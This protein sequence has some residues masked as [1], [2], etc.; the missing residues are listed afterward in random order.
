MKFNFSAFFFTAI[1]V[2]VAQFADGRLI[3]NFGNCPELNN[4]YINN[5]LPF[6]GP[7]GV[8]AG[9]AYTNTRNTP[10]NVPKNPSK[11]GGP[12]GL[13]MRRLS[14][15]PRR[16]A[17][18][19]ITSTFT[20]DENAP[21]D[22]D[23]PVA[24]KDF[25][26][27]NVQVEGVDEPDIIKTDGRR[28][29][30]LS[31]SILSVIQVLEDGAAGRRTGTLKL[32]I[33]PREMLFEGDYLL[34]I[35]T[36]YSYKRPVY[37]RYRV[38][39]SYGEQSTVVYQVRVSK[40]GKPSLVSTLHLEGDYL[41][42]REVDGVVRLVLRHKPLNSVWLYYPNGKV[43]RAQTE[44]WNREIIQ[45][46]QPG[47]WLPTY[48]LTING[49]VQKGVY[50]TCSDIFYSPNVF[51]GFNILTVVTLPIAGRLSP[52]S[53]ASIVSDADKVY[54]TSKTM[55]VTT[56]EYY[57]DDVST[58]STRWGNEY[59]TS[60]HKFALSQTGATY[61]A[62]GSVSGS[63]INQFAISEFEDTLFIATTNGA[64]WWSSRDLSR[65]KVTAFRTDE[66]SRSLRRVGQVGNLGIGERI[67]SVRYIRDTAYVV[68][69]REID[70]LYII[71]LSDPTKLRV[72]G[73]LKIPGFSTYLHPVGPGRLLG[74]GQDATLGGRT[75]GAKVSLF[76]VSDKS[77]PKEL[78][79]W[80][81]K[82]SYSD[83]EW[84]HRA[85]LYWTRE[86]V[87]VMP[88]NVYASRNTFQGAI[89]LDITPSEIKERG[90]I[91]HRLPGKK[92]T[93]SI[94]RNTIIGQVHLWSMSEELLQVNNI[95]NVKD[96]EDQVKISR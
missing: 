33:A 64:L 50:A 38:S 30:T 20:E 46:S 6:V 78:S 94:K 58:G 92:Y 36:D 21:D 34:A 53:S 7:Y 22:E 55:Y 52:A 86:R 81:L 95:K 4:Y 2:L 18:S 77:K 37:H 17:S 80:T 68:T 8:S 12:A 76:D 63:L 66:K 23:T 27:T 48:K 14:D 31:G 39:P 16:I 59:Q 67:F 60:I 25:S 35:A 96:V 71:D 28:V 93:P 83:A 70:P 90:R 19:N 3:Q 1:L 40:E 41:K 84:D 13:R 65:S 56:S 24:G 11:P 91:V 5:V 61:V 43:K 49:R 45:Y 32:P 26:T 82:G 75:T 29:Y 89:I 79:A 73:E 74:V 15:D 44:K 51:S 87:A 54:A 57:F 42:S 69:F 47:N 88:V 9:N 10:R 72:T 85:F 62:S